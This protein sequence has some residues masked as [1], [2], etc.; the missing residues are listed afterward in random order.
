MILEK[1]R[2][3]LSSGANWSG[4]IRDFPLVVDKGETDNLVGFCMDGV[5]KIS[6]TRLEVRKRDFT[7]KGDLSVLITKFFR[8]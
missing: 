1:V 5:T 4:P 6:P 3:A 8:M 7:P 2:Y